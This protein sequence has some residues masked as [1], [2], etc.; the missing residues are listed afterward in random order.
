M[1]GIPQ[2]FQQSS[3]I[4]LKD[5]H[6]VISDI[7]NRKRIQLVHPKFE[8]KHG[9]IMIYAAWCPHCRAKED[10]W[11]YLADQFNN[12]DSPFYDQNFRIAVID[13][14][15]PDAENII[16]ALEVGPV[17]RFMHVI[18]NQK[19]YGSANLF[20]YQGSDLN[21]ESLIR[22]VCDLSPTDAMCEFQ[23]SSL[24]PPPIE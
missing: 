1:N 23:S 21:P 24:K 8:D 2:M 11:S 22:E 5:E 15:D 9:Y 20:D 13:A 10:F 6:F 17:P 4:K 14:E 7:G 16:S 18:P 12:K 19:Q 3:V